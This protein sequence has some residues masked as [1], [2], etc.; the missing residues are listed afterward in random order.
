[1]RGKLQHLTQRASE[2]KEKMPN[3]SMYVTC[4]FFFNLSQHPHGL[5]KYSN[6][7]TQED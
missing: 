3:I 2:G 5:Y 1:M 6:N 7:Q 4:F